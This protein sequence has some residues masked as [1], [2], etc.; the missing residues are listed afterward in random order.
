M[1]LDPTRARSDN[2]TVSC[3][4]DNVV[5]LQKDE[6]SV[7]IAVWQLN[8]ECCGSKGIFPVWARESSLCPGPKECILLQAGELFYPPDIATW[9][10]LKESDNW[11]QIKSGFVLQKDCGCILPD[12]IVLHIKEM[13]QKWGIRTDA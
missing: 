11:E 10:L 7:D 6:D 1:R 3:R 9:T 13:Q 2:T 5:T 12:E 4:L 8:T